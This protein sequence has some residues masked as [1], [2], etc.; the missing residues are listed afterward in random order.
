VKQCFSCSS[1]NIQQAYTI[2][3]LDRIIDNTYKKSSNQELLIQRKISFT[4]EARI[5]YIGDSIY[6]GYYRIKK[7]STCVSGASNYG[8]IISFDFPLED[9]KHWIL[10]FISK[11]NFWMGGIDICWEDDDFKSEPYI[12]EV[13]PIHDII[14]SYRDKPYTE[15]KKT[16]EYMKYKKEGFTRAAGILIS[17]AKALNERP[18]IYCDIDCTISD[19]EPRI[20]KWAK[21]CAYKL[22]KHVIN[23]NPIDNSIEMLNKLYETYRIVFITARKSYECA[24][25]V[26]EKWLYKWGYKYHGLIVTNT[27]TEK[28]EYVKKWNDGNNIIFID[29]FTKNHEGTPYVDMTAYELFLAQNIKVY[30]FDKNNCNWDYIYSD[31]TGNNRE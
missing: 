21:D 24:R 8:S 27:M 10:T 22:Y 13:S 31:V 18:T 15:F 2:E 25:E 26:T 30:K 11:T 16:I 9:Y 1:N 28:L 23:D 14:E 3:E 19:S 4:H 6:H 5:T 17:H 12:L 29:D 20:R 7:D